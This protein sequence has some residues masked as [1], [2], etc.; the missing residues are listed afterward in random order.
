MTMQM[1]PLGASG[2]RVSALGFG[3]GPIGGLRNAVSDEA[4][5]ATVDAAW[6]SGIR[7]FDTAPL[8][9]HGQSERR[10]GEALRQRP[11]ADFTLS[12]KVGRLLRL[13]SRADFERHGFVDIPAL[14]IVYDYSRDGVLRSLEES[15]ERMRLG[16]PDIVLIHDP[17]RWTHGD[18]QPEFFRQALDEAFPALADLKTQGVIRAI[19]IGLNEADTAE[20]FLRHAEI[21]CVLLAGRY[22]LLEQGAA[23]KFLP[24]CVQ[25]NVGVI[26]GGPYNSGILVTGAVPG[27]HYN[28]AA[29]PDAVLARVARLAAALA[30][31]GVSLPAAAL[32]F[33]LRHPAVASVIPGM[34]SPEE[35]AVAVAGVQRT[36]P[37]D[38]WAALQA[39]GLLS[40][41]Q[42]SA[43]A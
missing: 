17:D 39:A 43:T 22:T 26:V 18:R 4:A 31:F 10:L 6:A 28:Y 36:V 33:P 16:P 1:R 3:G 38:A 37:E 13:A 12:T 15:L 34:L 7:Y 21:D 2:V 24:L 9:G 23:E 32:Q 41:G 11:R 35:V 5:A 29:A 30:P 14:E 8:Y 40:P 25:R 42:A 27:S 19:G 20:A